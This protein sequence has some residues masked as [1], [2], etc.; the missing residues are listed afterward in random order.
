LLRTI[1]V[2]RI[3]I[4]VVGDGSAGKDALIQAVF[5]INSQ[6]DPIAGSTETALTYP[7]N[8]QGNAFVVNY[9]GFN[10]YREGVDK[11]TDDY[12]Y[13]TDVF[14]M[15]VDINRGISGTDI[16][17]LR[18]LEK[19]DRK[20]L[21]CLN[22]VDLVRSEADLKK[23][24]KAA[25]DRLKGPNVD[26][27]MIDAAFDPDPRLGKRVSGVRYVYDRIREKIEEE[28]KLVDA[29]NFPPPPETL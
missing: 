4:G 18:N 28:G 10:D 17:I 22:K 6:I 26:E 5:G 29:E 15:V 8:K 13:H 1:L 9:P 12:L 19:Y 27:R 25:E 20:I 11:Y 3:T 16:R 2:N 23:L 7:L 14:V 24:K 21:I